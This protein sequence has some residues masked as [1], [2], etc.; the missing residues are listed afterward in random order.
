[1]EANVLTTEMI[2]VMIMI[3]VAVFL[4]I[5]E[6]I[7]VDMVAILMTVA[8]PL[9]HLVTP[10]EA[11][12]GFSSNAVIS[13]IAVIII[14]AGLDKTGVINRV[15]KP[16]MKIAGNSSSRIIIAMGAT[17]AGISS[18]MQNIGAA[19]LF[20]PAIKRV[21]K[22]MNISLSRMLMPIGFCAILG[23][24]ITLVGCSPLILLNDL[25]A[26]FNLKPFRLFDVSPIGLA[27]VGSGIAFFILF[28]RFVLPKGKVG[29]GVSSDEAIKGLESSY[30]DIGDHFE[31]K[32]PNDF[33]D[34]RDPLTIK[35]IREKYLV[36]VVAIA[37]RDGFKVFSA[38]PDME[39]RSDSDIAVYGLQENVDK[40]AKELGMQ[41]KDSL[42]VFQNEMSEAVSG[43]IEA[44][45]APRSDLIGKTLRKAHFWEQFQVNPL[46]IYRSDKAFYSGLSDFVLRSGDSILLHG[47]WERFNIL[48]QRHNFIFTTPVSEALKPE[49]AL[50]SGFWLAVALIM[51]IIFKIQLSVCLM[52]GAFG[53][54]VCRVLTIDEA[55][56]SVDWRTIFLLAGL[57]PLGIATEKTGTAAW[58]AYTILN[59]IGD[60]SP[61]VLLTA[62]AVLSTFFTLVISNVGAT[63]LL[64]PLVVNMAMAA[65]TDP[66]I[67]ALVVG[68]ATSNSFMLPTHQVNALYMGPGRYRSVDFI[69]AGGIM[70]VLFIAVLIGMLY[71]FYGI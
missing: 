29:D 9:L 35:D 33:T 18:F 10:K 49:K 40:M 16:V 51:I 6:W 55:Y 28:G 25:L 68:L 5:A 62:I 50:I 1:M 11:F 66:R 45:V 60:V 22:A 30:E 63:V 31:L 26:P 64:V 61:V 53:M 15:V 43:T 52:T 37:G 46:A 19:A 69:K 8:L 39:I 34:F 36:N 2:L 4:F 65:G 14:G 17:V 12:S 38:A 27:L 7:R 54:I 57:I 20:L 70:T 44:V 42:D 67:A 41:I 47:T 48:Q 13:I 71:L 59:L 23:G 56:K 32:V 24:T 21:S 58:I 3:G